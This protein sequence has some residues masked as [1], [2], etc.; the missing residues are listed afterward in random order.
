M[1]ERFLVSFLTSKLGLGSVSVKTGMHTPR[2][3]EVID[4][5]HSMRGTTRAMRTVP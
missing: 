4:H 1:D 3:E 5:I 2:K